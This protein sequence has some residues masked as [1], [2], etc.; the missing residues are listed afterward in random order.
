MSVGRPKCLS[1]LP[2]TPLSPMAL[3]RVLP[4]CEVRSMAQMCFSGSYGLMVIL[5]S[6]PN[7]S[8]HRDQFSTILPARRSRA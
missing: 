6:A 4:S 1:S 3:T 5:W 8:D 7:R 2:A